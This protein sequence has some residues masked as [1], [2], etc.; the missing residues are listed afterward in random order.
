MK[1]HV[2]TICWNENKFLHYFL[3]YYLNI[4]KVDHLFVYD[5]QSTDDSQSIINSYDNTTIIEYDTHNQIRDD[6]Y[7][8]IKNHEWK[9]Y[10]RGIGVD[11]V[12]VVDIDEIL[13]H[14]DGLYN[15]LKSQLKTSEIPNIIIPHGYQMYSKTFPNTFTHNPLEISHVGKK[16][17]DFNKPAIFNPDTISDINYI[18]GCHRCN[19]TFNSSA[20]KTLNIKSDDE[21]VKLL[22]YKFVYGVD[23]LIERYK[24]YQSRLSSINKVHGWGKHYTQKINKIKEQYEH[25]GIN[26]VNIV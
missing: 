13:Y 1:I 10:S 11:F 7:L 24:L 16:D 5:N 25:A 18:A 17:I 14:S 23:Y 26:C 21:N 15:Y 3:N 20:I 9:K 6:V 22:H 2:Y 8:Q 19:P 4:V 12:F